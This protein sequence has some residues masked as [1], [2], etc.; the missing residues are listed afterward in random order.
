[1]LDDPPS[2]PAFPCQRMERDLP[3]GSLDFP[4]N[5]HLRGNPAEGSVF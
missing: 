4:G 1:M 3:P 5:S 2:G